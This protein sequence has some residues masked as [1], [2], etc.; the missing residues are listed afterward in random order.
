VRFADDDLKAGT[1]DIP[2]GQRSADDGSNADGEIP[3]HVNAA[4]R[5]RAGRR[6]KQRAN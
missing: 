4:I 6:R 3:N 1:D 5:R 2:A